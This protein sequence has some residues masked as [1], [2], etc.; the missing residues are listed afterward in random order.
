MINAGEFWKAAFCVIGARQ[1]DR[2][3]NRIT[4]K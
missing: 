1:G 3:D 2:F 4:S